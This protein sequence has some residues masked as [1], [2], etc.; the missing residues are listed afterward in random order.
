MIVFFLYT[1]TWLLLG[2]FS[3]FSYPL[4]IARN[5]FFQSSTLLCPAVL[6]SSEKI[7]SLSLVIF[8]GVMFALYGWKLWNEFKKLELFPR[9]K[10]MVLLVAALMFVAVLVVPFGSSDMSYYFAA[11]RAQHQG[12]NIYHDQWGMEKE[13]VY[14]IPS[15]TIV[16]FSYG[17]IIAHVFSMLYTISNGQILWFM[18]LWKLFM[19]VSILFCSFCI[20][21]LAGLLGSKINKKVLYGVFLLQPLLVF[22]TVVNGHFDVLWLICVLV[23]II[24]AHKKRWAWVISLLVIGVWVK[25]VPVLIAPFFVLWW[26]QSFSKENWKRQIVQTLFGVMVGVLTTVIVWHKYWIGPDVFQSVLIQSKWA[27]MSLFA[28]LYFS[29]KP[30]FEIWFEGGAHWILTRLVQASLLII[31]A[32]ILW[33][34]VKQV[35]L[36]IR[37]KLVWS[38]GQYV[39]AVF[40]F[41]LTYLLVWQK[42]F[43][44]WYGLW[45][46]PF[47][48]I[49]YSIYENP[50]VLRITRWITITPLVY[51]L[52]WLIDWFLTRTDAGNELWFYISIVAIVFVYPLSVIIEWRK[53]RFQMD[54]ER[55][56]ETKN[57]VVFLIRQVYKVCV[58]FP[59]GVLVDMLFAMKNNPVEKTEYAYCVLITSVIY[60]K[61]KELSYSKIRSVYSPDERYTQ[62]LTTIRSI[63]EKMP[64]ARIVCIEAGLEAVPFDLQNHVDE[65][66]YVGKNTLVRRAC[67]SGLKSLGETSM[68]L[69]VANKLPY[70]KRYFKISGRYVLNN[71]F[72]LE[73]W[74]KGEVVYHYIR[75]DFVSTRLY[76]FSESAKK[77]WHKAL[78]KGIP[79]LLLDYPIEHVLVRFT[80]KKFISGI[81]TVGVVG[82]DG[83]NGK[84][85]KE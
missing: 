62:T 57:M 50:Y 70:A 40:V 41:L 22:E 4:I 38:S 54:K 37:K 32:Y 16:G 69:A 3:V 45:F 71:E 25:F 11:G 2:S 55:L 77:I 68:L 82:N 58:A 8:M 18:F 72:N 65:Y 9:F 61:E 83:T 43:L 31:F 33:P 35:V 66:I 85:V 78:L 75:P 19:A 74:E 49:L 21:N 30:L 17:P 76:S 15:D 63:R 56:V 23:A 1:F 64:E 12:L 36:I 53:S 80:P 39:G 27:V 42:S 60:P 28:V 34:Y 13:F 59:W 44:P 67:D 48:I 7:L 10:K 6:S 24:E 52:L 20:I 84:E 14:P 81:E 5:C 51:Y 47:G 46:L 26:W 73:N 79:Y 29:L